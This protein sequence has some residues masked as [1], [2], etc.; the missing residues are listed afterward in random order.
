MLIHISHGSSRLS[1]WLWLVVLYNIYV[2]G[3]TLKNNIFEILSTYNLLMI[4]FSA[5]HILSKNAIIKKFLQ[6]QENNIWQKTTV[7]NECLNCQVIVGKMKESSE[8]SEKI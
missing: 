4:Y 8:S 6:L 5:A 1:R 2:E 7:I 3:K